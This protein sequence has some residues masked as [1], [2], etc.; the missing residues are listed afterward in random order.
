[1]EDRRWSLSAKRPK[2]GRARAAAAPAAC[3]L[4]VASPSTANASLTP[5]RAASLTPGRAASLTPGRAASLTPGRAAS[6]TPGRAASSTPARAALLLAASLCGLLAVSTARAYPPPPHPTRAAL[7]ALS[8][9]DKATAIMLLDAVVSA[10]PSD[11]PSLLLLADLLIRQG[12]TAQARALLLLSPGDPDALARLA[13]LSL[14][15]GRPKEARAHIDAALKLSPHHPCATLHLA[16][17]F[18]LSGKRKQARPHLTSLLDRYN[19]AK[20]FSAQDLTCAG[21]AAQ[22]LELFEEANKIFFAA[23]DADP[24]DPTPLIHAGSLLLTKFNLRDAQATFDQALSLDPSHPDALLGSARAA[25]DGDFNLPLARSLALQA[26]SLNPSHLPSLALLAHLCLLD[27]DTDQARSYLSQA[28]KLNP[29]HLPSLSLLAASHYL[30]DDAPSLAATQAAVLKLNPEYAPLFTTLAEHAEASHRY[31]ESIDL[32]KKA[33]ALD[34]SHWAAFQGLGLALT[35]AGDDAA[36]LEYLR[37]AFALDP[38]NVRAFNLLEL[39]DKTLPSYSAQSLPNGVTLRLHYAD[40]P[41]LSLFMPPLIDQALSS[42]S[43]QYSIP[44]PLPLTIEVFHDPTSFSIRALGLPAPSPQG[45]C[46]GPL[47]STLS[48][49]TSTLNW[50]QIVWHELAHAFHLQLSNSRVPRWFTEGLAEYDTSLAHPSWRREHDLLL[51]L[52]LQAGSLPPTADLNRAFTS[53][54]SSS[55]ISLAY[56]LSFLTISFIAE[57]HGAQTLPLMLRAFATHDTAAVF[58]DT[59]DT[60][61]SDFDAAFHAWLSRRL[62]FLDAS[63]ELDLDSLYTHLAALLDAASTPPDNPTSLSLAGFSLLLHN[64]LPAASSLAQQALSL[65]PQHLLANYLQA[66]LHLHEGAYE[67]ADALFKKLLTLGADGYSFRCDLAAL[68]LR[69]G[70]PDRAIEHYLQ[71]SRLYPSGD[72]PHRELARLYLL[73]NQP[74]AALT[75]L[76]TLLSIDQSSLPTALLA[77]DTASQL[78]QTTLAL[79]FARHALHIN[80]FSPPLLLSSA[81][82]A[83]AAQD[84]PLAERSLTA[85]LSTSPKDP[86]PSLLLLSHLYLSTQR[87]LRA[88]ETLSRLQSIDPSHPDLPPLLKRLQHL[89]PPR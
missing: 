65:D 31:V 60:P 88:Q 69:L 54:A 47:I 30:D 8:A 34:P 9:N 64:D 49:S 82:L 22:S 12:D 63:F 77:I 55:D 48:P 83:I 18:E 74:A 7:S 75:H 11:A 52:R 70:L 10:D 80:P 39:Y 89:S 17:L 4:T 40:K 3:A 26:L 59:L 33:L 42:L 25:L 53:A 35:R 14:D 43:A 41:I 57:T 76:T 68:S 32:Y 27:D 45:I 13:A 78:S 56:Y 67:D 2:R 81:Q 29:S 73:R 23:H 37:K 46:F 50:A 44:P 58:L 87:P 86:T 84:W 85:L 6:L 38:Y 16:Q 24:L 19:S 15:L 79:D 5:G 62:A 71:A 61:L 1:M 21:I 20:L 28:L 72:E 51:Y 36:G 66:S